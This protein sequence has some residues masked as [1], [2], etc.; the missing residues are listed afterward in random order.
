LGCSDGLGTGARLEITL[1]IAGPPLHELVDHSD[2]RSVAGPGVGRLIAVTLTRGAAV[3]FASSAHRHRCPVVSCLPFIVP[4][5]GK[6]G[7]TWVGTSG[8]GIAALDGTS[9]VRGQSA[10]DPILLAGLNGPTQAGLNNLT[11]TADSLGFFY[12]EKRGAGVPDRE[13][14]LGVHA[15]ASSTITPSHQDRAPCIEGGAS[16]TGVNSGGEPVGLIR[17]LKANVSVNAKV[18]AKSTSRVD[19]PKVP[20]WQGCWNVFE[21]VRSRILSGAQTHLGRGRGLSV[22]VGISN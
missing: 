21:S 6:T 19:S 9:F 16:S 4:I 15:E 17:S 3:S 8:T 14:Q 20:T 12:L 18:N 2:S 11:A 1:P 10:P 13:E 22:S 5:S 7:C